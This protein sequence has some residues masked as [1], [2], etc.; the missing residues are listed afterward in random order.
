VVL[1]KHLINVF[2][3]EVCK[4]NSQSPLTVVFLG[5]LLVTMQPRCCAQAS[6]ETKAAASDKTA[7]LLIRDAESLPPEF[8]ADIL[9][10]VVEDGAS[11]TASQKTRALKNAFDEAAQSQDEVMR[12]PW[13][14]SVEETSEGL[15]ALAL[16]A[17][18]LDRISQQSRAVED[19][20]GIDPK[21]ARAKLGTIAL[22]RFD[23]PPCYATWSYFPDAYYEAVATVMATSF[24]PEEISSGQRGEFLRSVVSRVVSHAQLPPV[25]RLITVS[26]LSGPELANVISSYVYTLDGLRGDAHSFYATATGHSVDEFVALVARLDKQGMVVLPLITSL[27]RY[28]VAN[29]KATPCDPIKPPDNGKLPFAVQE[30]NDKFSTRLKAAG[31][32]AITDDEIKNDA[33]D[34][35]PIESEPSRWN[36]KEYSD[37]LVSVQGLPDMPREAPS[38]E[39][40]YQEYLLRL[41]DWSNQ[42]EPEIEFFH[43]K[44]IFYLGVIERLGPSALRTNTLTDFV[45]FLEQNSY[46]QVSKVD[47]FLYARRLIDVSSKL[48]ERSEVINALTSSG[49]PVLNL[50]GRLESWKGKQVPAKRLAEQ[51]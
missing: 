5:W 44:S 26:D 10:Q 11:L 16:E 36:S 50:Y 2:R 41:N 38:I 8:A 4:L 15:H 22:P 14:T 27:R 31:S 40:K 29:F 19:I 51:K 28:L 35:P 45:K 9:L 48:A 25:T 1:R 23:P 37:L 20:A 49:D 32:T 24:S 34:T 3:I 33:K 46:Q 13:G 39:A 12:R 7:L 47:W 30:F 21:L 42:S 17:G 18:R 6:H 43:Q